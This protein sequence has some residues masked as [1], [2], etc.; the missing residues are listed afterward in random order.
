M[1][2][3]QNL[4]SIYNY[5]LSNGFTYDKSTIESLYLSLKTFPFAVI[6][7]G[8][9]SGKT[10]LARLFA[11]GCGATQTNGRFKLVSVSSDWDSPARL[12]GYL[13]PEGKFV[14]GIISDYI[15]EASKDGE[16]PYFLCLDE[17]N[18][19]RPEHYMCPI[20]SALEGRYFDEEGNIISM[21]ILDSSSFGSDISA[22]YSYSGLSIPDNLYILGT[23]NYD[24]VSY[25]L[26]PKFIDRVFFVDLE[27]DKLQ[28]DFMREI[29][30]E[31][32]PCIADNSFLKSEYL[33][34]PDFGSDLEFLRDYTVFWN[35]FNKLITLDAAKISY[36]TRNQMLFYGFYTREFKLFDTDSATDLLILQ[37]I[38]PRI[39]GMSSYVEKSLKAVFGVCMG[40][41]NSRSEE[42][43]KSAYNMQLAVINHKCR[44][45][46]SA[47]KIIKMMRKYEEDGYTG[48]WF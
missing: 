37:K 36:R 34:L 3:S 10:S 6:G 9:G 46:R 24:D 4:D 27:S 26:S 25:V 44:Y 48:F 35:T 31:E 33:S 13:N 21:P 22:K 8:S 11:A 39:S 23:L 43:V 18:L 42:F 40:E 12:L 16:N 47:N 30:G 45:P 29:F 28:V 15:Q 17:I 2:V 32:K 14:P 1:T 38:L 20:I 41:P 5:I 7:G 19:S